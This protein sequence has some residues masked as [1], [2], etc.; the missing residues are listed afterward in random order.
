M[1]IDNYWEKDNT[2]REIITKKRISSIA[3]FNLFATYYNL[4]DKK[5]VSMLLRQD[6]NI[7]EGKLFVK[8]GFHFLILIDGDIKEFLILPN[9]KIYDF[10]SR[11]AMLINNCHS[12]NEVI[13]LLIDEMK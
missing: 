7:E 9:D 12:E 2:R 5:G 13:D 6:S 11:I 3:N 10:T 8:N 4:M 1:I